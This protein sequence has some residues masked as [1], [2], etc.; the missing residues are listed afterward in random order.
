MSQVVSAEE[1]HQNPVKWMKRFKESVIVYPTDTIYG[2]GCPATSPALVL[3]IREFKQSHLQ[4]FSVIAPSKEWI[5]Q[6]CDVKPEHEPWLAKLPGPYTLIFKLKD[7]DCVAF[8]VLNGMD[9]IGVRI[10][11]HWISELVAKLNLPFITTSANVTAGEFMTSLDDLNLEIKHGV[12][13]IL[14]E[15]E[16]TGRPS[17]IVHLEKQGVEIKKR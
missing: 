16:K 14:Y 1:Y 4:P 7:K 13:F 10:P 17:A 6:H 11:D 9:S 2:L 12:D 3:R 5:R 8:N 15:G